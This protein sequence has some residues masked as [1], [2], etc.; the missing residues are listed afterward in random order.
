MIC[1]R[2][3]RK[4]VVVPAKLPQARRIIASAGEYAQL[5]AEAIA[6]ASANGAALWY[7]GRDL[8]GVFEDSGGTIQAGVGS[9]VGLLLDRQYGLGRAS[10]YPATQATAANK[11]AVMVL[12]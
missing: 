9:P 12:P 5:E 4:P 6:A 2:P 8:A 1:G 10:G 7:I 11:P 3:Q